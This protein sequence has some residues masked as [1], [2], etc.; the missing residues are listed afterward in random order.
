MAQAATTMMDAA[1]SAL[2]LSR[3][4]TF[5]TVVAVLAVPWSQRVL[6]LRWLTAMTLVG[7]TFVT[8]VSPR[9]FQIPV[10][11][12]QSITIQGRALQIIDIITHWLPFVYIH[13]TNTKDPDILWPTVLFCTLYIH[14]VGGWA[15]VQ[16]TYHITQYDLAVILVAMIAVSA[17][18][19]V[20]TRTT[21]AA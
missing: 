13:M 21:T 12:N 14:Y 11:N 20:S 6:H 15:G 9:K 19:S 18:F 17:A 3:Y 2:S 7:G 10:G 8:Y 1:S 16:N 4:F 5:W